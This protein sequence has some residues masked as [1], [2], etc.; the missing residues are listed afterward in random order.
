M[1]RRESGD[2]RVK[3]GSNYPL[4][5]PVLARDDPVEPRSYPLWSLG[6]TYV[7]ESEPGS[8]RGRGIGRIARRDAELGAQSSAY[9]VEPQQPRHPLLSL[10]R[11]PH[12]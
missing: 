3:T 1:Q 8:R 2:L 4:G 9:T 6:G 7:A 11:R 5:V 10:A 12:R